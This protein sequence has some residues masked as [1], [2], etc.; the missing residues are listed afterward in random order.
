MAEE[1]LM[2]KGLNHKNIIH[3]LAV[4]SSNDCTKLIIDPVRRG[5]LKDVLIEDN[6]DTMKLEEL[7]NIAGQVRPTFSV[8]Y[9]YAYMCGLLQ[10]DRSKT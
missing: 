1:I 10:T 6:G 3:L 8:A 9:A 5:V 4:T 2:L 7:E